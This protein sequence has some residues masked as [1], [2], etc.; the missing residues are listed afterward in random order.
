MDARRA[1]LD[2]AQDVGR[3]FRRLTQKKKPQRFGK[4]G[5]WRYSQCLIGSSTQISSTS[6]N[7]LRR[8]RTRKSRADIERELAEEEQKLAALMKQ[9]KQKER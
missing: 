5:V 4:G 8:K 7:C 6:R 3:R 1:R 9:R 2:L